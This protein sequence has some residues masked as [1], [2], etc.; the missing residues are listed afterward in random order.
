[1]LLTKWESYSWTN[2][3]DGAEF[4][5]LCDYEGR[6]V[7]GG[8]VT[9]CIDTLGNQLFQ[10]PLVVI[11]ERMRVHARQI[12]FKKIWLAERSSNDEIISTISR[13]MAF[14]Q[15]QL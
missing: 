10:K 8:G 11:S 2:R 6:I 12:G 5:Y 7:T 13:N 4:A 9:L 1:M 14:T 15:N 3:P